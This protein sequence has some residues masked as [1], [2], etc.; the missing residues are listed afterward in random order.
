M[1]AAGILF[2][3]TGWL[4]IT[5][6]LTCVASLN[7][8]VSAVLLGVAILT[9]IAASKKVPPVGWSAINTNFGVL[10]SPLANT[11]YW[12]SVEVQTIAQSAFERVL[13]FPEGVI[14]WWSD[15]TKIFWHTQLE[16]DHKIVLV[17]SRIFRNFVLTFAVFFALMMYSFVR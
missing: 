8:R 9:N 15:E 2:P 12:A 14:P 4:G 3:A 11:Q 6:T 1:I 5:L 13:I 10:T 16:R 17:G 7:K